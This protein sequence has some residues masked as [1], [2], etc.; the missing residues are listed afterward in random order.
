MEATYR[1]EQI[2][3]CRHCNAEWRIADHGTICPRC[4]K[5]GGVATVRPPGPHQPPRPDLSPEGIRASNARW[6]E[7]A[8]RYHLTPAQI[9]ELRRQA[10]RWAEVEALAAGGA[11]VLVEHD[12]EGLVAHR[13]NMPSGHILATH[14]TASAGKGRQGR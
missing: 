13:L 2:L 4:G 8:A 7:H 1:P 9:D 3:G 10:A 6:A 11:A 12:G 14:Q 5:T